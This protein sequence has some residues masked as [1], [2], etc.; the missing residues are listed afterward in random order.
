MKKIMDKILLLEIA[1]Y[2]L[3]QGHKYK[4]QVYSG[5]KKQAIISGGKIKTKICLHR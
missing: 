5:C 1:Y 4:S 2:V 3:R